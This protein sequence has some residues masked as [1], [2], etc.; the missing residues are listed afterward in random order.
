MPSTCPSPLRSAAGCAGKTS[1]RIVTGAESANRP[2]LSQAINVTSYLPA[3]VKN[4]ACS[5]SW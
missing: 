4:A 2:L 5:C 3:A 1:N